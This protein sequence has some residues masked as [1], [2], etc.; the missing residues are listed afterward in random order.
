MQAMLKHTGR[1]VNASISADEWRNPDVAIPVMQA[2]A[3]WEKGPGGKS[4]QLSPEQWR[5]AHATY[6][7]GGRRSGAPG[8]TAEPMAM[9][10]PPLEGG[11]AEA[12]APGSGITPRP[13]K[14]FGLDPH[15]R[16][17][18]AISPMVQR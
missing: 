5:A 1:D 7:G 9:G 15:A 6:L 11:T 18:D 2:M 10:M 12:T 13:V 16:K 8:A 14:I 4:F 17:S 3:G